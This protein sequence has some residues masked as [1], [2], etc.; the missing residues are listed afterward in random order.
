MKENLAAATIVREYRNRIVTSGTNTTSAQIGIPQYLEDTDI[1]N[2]YVNGLRLTDTEYTATEETITF[3]KTIDED[4]TIIEIVVQKSIDGSDAETVVAEVGV[5]QTQVNNLTQEHDALSEEVTAIQGSFRTPS[6]LYSGTLAVTQL[7]S[8]VYTT[9]SGLSN[10]DIVIVR[11]EIGTV[12]KEDK[13]FY[14][15]TMTS[16]TQ[17]QSMSAYLDS[18]HDGFASI[19]CDLAQNRVGIRAEAVSG[20]EVNTVKI[21]GVFGIK[22]A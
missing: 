12:G 16:N 22:L 10:Y 11:C 21:T 3:T 15:G 7:S 8:M 6:K 9:I 20:W 13:I 4:G 17:T 19:I 14:K 1:L 2:V 5:L 18:T